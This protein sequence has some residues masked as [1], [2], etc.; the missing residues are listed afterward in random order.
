[1]QKPCDTVWEFLEVFAPFHVQGYQALYDYPIGTELYSTKRKPQ[2]WTLELPAESPLSFP[3]DVQ[4]QIDRFW[5]KYHQRRNRQI[6]R[7]QSEIVHGVTRLTIRT[8]NY[9]RDFGITE[10][11]DWHW[12]TCNQLQVSPEKTTWCDMQHRQ[13]VMETDT[14]RIFQACLV[15]Y[16]DCGTAIPIRGLPLECQNVRRWNTVLSHGLLRYKQRKAFEREAEPYLIQD[17]LCIAK[18]YI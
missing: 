18:L 15:Q 9:Y 6:L 16:P 12:S 17:L 10:N 4:T 11:E 2:E 5:Y 8:R 13:I 1:M 3:D 7:A 14:G